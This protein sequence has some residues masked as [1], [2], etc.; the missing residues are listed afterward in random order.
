[1]PLKNLRVITESLE[2]QALTIL[3]QY[4][5]VFRAALESE[6]LMELAREHMNTWDEDEVRTLCGAVRR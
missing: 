2:Q 1:M 6:E 5:Y 4:K 3:F